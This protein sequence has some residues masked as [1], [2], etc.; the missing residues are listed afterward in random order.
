MLTCAE[1]LVET[2]I[3]VDWRR[4]ELH[5]L[6]RKQR[7]RIPLQSCTHTISK[8]EA[9]FCDQ[10]LPDV[11]INE[12]EAKEE[13]NF[14]YF[15]DLKNSTLGAPVLKTHTSRMITWFYTINLIIYIF[16][17]LFYIPYLFMTWIYKRK[18]LLS[19]NMWNNNR[20]LISE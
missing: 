9:L 2:F 5:P 20:S 19:T 8:Q 7:I 12:F 14:L 6:T 3:F 11:I 10:S 4:P 13:R 1:V 17:F 18:H 16:I 15:V